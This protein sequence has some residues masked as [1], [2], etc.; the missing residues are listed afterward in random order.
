M[1]IER[2]GRAIELTNQERLSAYYEQE[3]EFDVE[4]VRG[5]L[6]GY[7]DGEDARIADIAAALLEDDTRLSAIAKVKRQN[8]DKYDMTWDVATQ[9]AVKKA[10]AAAETHGIVPAND[11]STCEVTEICPHCENEVTMTWNTDTDGFKAVCPHCGGRLMLCDECRHTKGVCDYCRET[12]TCR[13]NSTGTVLVQG[14]EYR[15]YTC[16]YCGHEWLENCGAS[17]Y[18]GY[19]PVC[20]RGLEKEAKR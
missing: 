19:C 1:K 14:E 12:D 13:M 9:D 2:H 15:K 16:L 8:M 11:D 4:D 10:L 18:P 5:E 7:A 3:H 20:A 17:G 6:A